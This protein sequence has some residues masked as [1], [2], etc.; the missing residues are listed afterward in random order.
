[1]D[2][3]SIEEGAIDLREGMRAHPDGVIDLGSPPQVGEHLAKRPKVRNV[4]KIACFRER[5]G[6]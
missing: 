3:P 2:T 1:M 6:S 4:T 5:F